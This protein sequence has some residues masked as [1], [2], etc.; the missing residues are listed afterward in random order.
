[1]EKEKEYWNNFVII[2]KNMGSRQKNR[3]G[4]IICTLKIMEEIKI[5]M[6]LLI[7]KLL[8]TSIEYIN[9]S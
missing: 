5:G 9:L 2:N 1:M 3:K 7:I 6:L 4:N 8:K